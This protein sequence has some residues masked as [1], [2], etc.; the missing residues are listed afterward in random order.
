[1]CVQSL[2]IFVVILNEI[3]MCLHRMPLHSV[4]LQPSMSV[5]S[6][7]DATQLN[8]TP[9]IALKGKVMYDHV[10]NTDDELSVF[11]NEVNQIETQPF[12]TQQ[13]S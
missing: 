10:A 1:M 9:K 11:A 4:N 5:D 2:P 6:S 7:E 12:P 8:E 13:P 3:N